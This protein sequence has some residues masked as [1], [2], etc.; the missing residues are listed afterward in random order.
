MKSWL[1]ESGIS[2]DRIKQ[3]KGLNWIK[4]SATVGEA[5][6]LLR[7]EYKIYTNLETGKDHL[8]CE[9]YS[10]PPHIQ[11]HIDFITPT[12]HFDAYV[13]TKKKRCDLEGRT[14]KVKP[15]PIVHPGSNVAPQPQIAYTLANC[16]QYV[17]PECLR[18]LYGFSNGTLSA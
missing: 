3:S 14:I 12:T 13:K 18:A 15:F 10:V 9:D 11:E 7:T 17:T 5:E 2:H 4:F 8:A 1:F 16:Y 6:S